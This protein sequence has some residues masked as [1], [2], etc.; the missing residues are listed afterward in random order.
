MR[1]LIVGLNFQPELTGI[2]KYTAEMVAYLRAAGH[3]VRVITTPPY[4]PY[5]K[6]QPGYCWW[7]YRRE[8]WSGVTV[9]R[10]PLW[11][12]REPSGF[13]RILHLLSFALSSLPLVLGQF[14]WSPQIVLCVAPSL[15]SAP[16]ALLVGRLRRAKTWLHI[17][18]FELDA[19]ARLGM[20]GFGRALV[21]G[22]ARMESR[23]LRAFDRASTI[24]SRMLVHLEGK[25]VA[26]ERTYLFPNWVDVDKIFPI[27]HGLESLRKEFGI[28]SGKIIVLYAGNMGVKQGLEILT[29]AARCLRK[30]SSFHFVLCGEGNARES[31]ERETREMQNVQFL[32][33]QPTEKLNR[34]LNT[35]DIH[36]L[37]QRADAADLVMP[38]KLLGMLASGKAI[39]ATANKGTEIGNIVGKVGVLV[40][41]GDLQA[42][43]RAILELGLSPQMRERMGWQGRAFACEHWNAER[44]LGGF[45]QHLQELV[46]RQSKKMGSTLLI[47]R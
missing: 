42:L 33:L 12:P 38:S 2:G 43:C 29:E 15:F 31:L 34:L 14:F 25:G 20:L 22:V 13:K 44:I 37:P 11:V 35:A 41:P 9:Y 36:I 5:W 19:A 32:P 4:Y 18:D 3:Q 27:S 1:I 30:N 7:A 16:I 10:C 47:K 45:E 8:S 28:P 40:P 6:V 46:A 21:N 24:S 17:Q 23:I 26:A 39:I